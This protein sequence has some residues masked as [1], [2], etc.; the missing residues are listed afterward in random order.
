MITKEEIYKRMEQ[1]PE[2]RLGI[3][4]WIEFLMERK[5]HPRNPKLREKRL[6]S[7]SKEI[8]SLIRRNKIKQTRKSEWKTINWKA[9]TKKTDQHTTPPDILD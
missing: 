6:T 1:T 4:P 3:M 2:G 8:S 7:A 9:C 5:Q